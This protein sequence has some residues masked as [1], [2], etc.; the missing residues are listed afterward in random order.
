MGET[1]LVSTPLSDRALQ[2]QVPGLKDEA[3]L[4][5]AIE[6]AHE[7]AIL[8]AGNSTFIG[9]HVGMVMEAKNLATHISSC[10]PTRLTSV[11]SGP[12]RWR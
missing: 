1:W 10:V 7:A 2:A 3:T 4:A 5:K 12:L 6:L 8:E 11:G 9:E